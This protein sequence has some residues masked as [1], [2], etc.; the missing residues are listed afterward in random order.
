MKLGLNITIDHFSLAS[1]L[2]PNGVVEAG[3]LIE[4]SMSGGT[5]ESPETAEFTIFLAGCTD[6]SL[7]QASNLSF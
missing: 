5:A 3:T 1:S 6:F 2:G 7:A 4:L